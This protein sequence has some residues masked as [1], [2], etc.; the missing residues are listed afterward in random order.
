VLVLDSVGMTRGIAPLVLGYQA[1]DPEINIVGVILN[2]VGGPRHEEKLR[3]VIERYTDVKVLGAVR[4][5]DR[6]WR[7]S[8]V[9]WG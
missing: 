8:S 2:K 5:D 7:S 9:I 3:A 6:N 1:F 4:M